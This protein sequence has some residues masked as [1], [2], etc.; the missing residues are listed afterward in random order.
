[1]GLVALSAVVVAVPFLMGDPGWLADSDR[2]LFAEP[3]EFWPVL[4]G[5]GALPL[6]LIDLKWLRVG[7]AGA[8]LAGAG[9]ISARLPFG[10]PGIEEALL[11]MASFGA[12]LVVAAALDTLDLDPRRAM[13]LIG[14][15]AIL[16]LSVLPFANGRFGLP[17]GDLIGRI[18]FAQALA[19]EAGPGRVL[20][21]SSERT[22]IPG[23]ARSGPGFW[24]RLV[25]GSGMTQDEVWLPSR[26]EG[27]HRLAEILERIAG[28]DELRPGELLAEFS[29]DWV[30]LDGPSF[31]LDEVLVAQLDL[32]PTPLD[33]AS[34][35][36][37]NLDKRPIADAGEQVWRREG[38]GYGGE[39]TITPVLLAINHD[40]GWE[41]E[42]VRSDWAV[43]VDGSTGEARYR[44]TTDRLAFPVAT[45]VLTLAG[46][47]L[48]GMG[49]VRS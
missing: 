2:R 36:Y 11:V 20:M 29:I 37:E 10:G 19:G 28:G 8:I 35:V 46:L 16:A 47:V 48:M 26:A 7:A 30:V 18:A 21:A 22:D 40:E 27:D 4:I 43:A 23:D 33:P 45:M 41:Q 9:L 14:G 13:A 32:V 5:L 12:G 17:A 15:L 38:A 44:G 34:R 24:Y 49:R 1:M 39:A 42:A 25:D 31:R 6:F 3:D